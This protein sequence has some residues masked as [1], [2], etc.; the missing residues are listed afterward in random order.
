MKRLFDASSIFEIAKKLD[1]SPIL[2]QNTLTLTP[3]ELGNILMKHVALT[4]TLSTSEVEDLRR[5]INRMLLTMNLYAVEEIDHETLKIAIE[6]HTSYYDASYLHVA[7]E[8]NAELVTEDKRLTEA[9]KRLNIPCQ[10]INT[11]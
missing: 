7:K 9:A 3:Y 11:L 8:L 5:V 4:H 10:S 6:R 2:D 1:S